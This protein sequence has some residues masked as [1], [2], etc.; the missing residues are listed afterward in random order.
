MAT[1]QIGENRRDGCDAVDRR[2]GILRIINS[3][4]GRPAA[5][6]LRVTAHANV[7]MNCNHQIS[8]DYFGLARKKLEARFQCP[9]MLMQGA[10]G[11][12]KPAGTDKILGGGFDDLER[13]SDLLVASAEQAQADSELENSAD[14]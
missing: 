13:I 11:N 12:I 14:C 5:L 2:L 9:V 8:S 4:T 7:L 3:E 6:L 1:T 10:S